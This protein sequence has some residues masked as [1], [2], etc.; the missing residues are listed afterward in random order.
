MFIDRAHA[1][2]SLARLLDAHDHA[3][4]TIVLGI[5]RGG[6]V[7]AA[8]VAAALGLPL[9]VAV[10]AKV[11][12]PGNPEFAIGAVAPD[13]EVIA[14]PA[15]GF[16]AEEVK[17]YSGDAHAKVELYLGM[18]RSG[19]APLDVRGKTVLLVDDGLA[20]GLTTR[21]AVEWLC[22]SGASKVVVAAPV[23]SPSA[24][25]FLEGAADEV[26]VAAVPAGF[27]AV[28]Q[29]YE[30]FGQTEDEEVLSLLRAAAANGD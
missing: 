16:S 9:D 21:A 25:S 13:G 17:A 1:G 29:F 24:V 20:T 14:N 11:G 27:Y 19:R 10:A 3:P 15:A 30:R 23:G 22:R 12:A 6:V 2:R 8:E 7:V 18:L 26:V 4:S 5:P 28:G